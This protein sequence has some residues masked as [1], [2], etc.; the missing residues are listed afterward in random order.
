M[1]IMDTLGHALMD[2][3]T[4]HFSDPPE[5]LAPEER[6]LVALSSPLSAYN[7]D[8]IDAVTSRRDPKTQRKGLAEMWDVTDR[9][10]FENTARWLVEEGHRGAYADIWSLLVKLDASVQSTHPVLRGILAMTFPSYHLIKLR[11]QLDYQALSA[12]SG[13]SVEEVVRLVNTGADWVDGIRGL[14]GIQPGAIQSLLAWDAVRLVSLTRW[15]LQLGYITT[16]EEFCTHAGALSAEVKR[17][18]GD[19]RAFGAAFLAGALIWNDSDARCEAMM[20]T[21]RLLLKDP[22]SPFQTVPWGSQGR[23]SA[24]R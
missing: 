4:L 2:N 11:K 6:W 15:A 24:D 22:R 1:G 13:K 21:H 5:Q 14:Y 18:Y 7:G 20:R 16:M 10:S 23:S 17:S 9:T 12:S 19:W 8:L 3:D